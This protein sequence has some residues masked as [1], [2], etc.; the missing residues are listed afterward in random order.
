MRTETYEKVWYTYDELSESAQENARAKHNQFEWESG[1]MQESMQL[2]AD[3]ILED[4]GLS[5]ASDLTY[6]LYTQGGY[7]KFATTGPFEYGGVTYK[8]VTNTSRWGGDIELFYPDDEWRDDVPVGA[9]V[10]AEQFIVNLS[11][12]MYEAFIAEDEYISSDEAFR[13]TAEAN[14]WE[15]DEEGNL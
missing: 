3:G 1:W 10:A 7:P 8:L 9:Q 15:F 14:D 2:I 5:M 13:E 6:S 11:R 4:A 12:K